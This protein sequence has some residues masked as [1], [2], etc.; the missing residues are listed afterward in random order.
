[1]IIVCGYLIVDADQRTAYLRG[2]EAVV[3]LA[4]AATGNLDFALS[5]DLVDAERINVLERWESRDALMAFR[6]DGPSAEQ[7]E[8]IRFTDVNEYV[9]S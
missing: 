1:M 8:Q 9:M 7:Q 4:R 5:P 3:E 6:S 2:C